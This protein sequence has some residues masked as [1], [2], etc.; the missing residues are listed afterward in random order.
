M[1][2]IGWYG[3]G[4]KVKGKYDNGDNTWIGY[5][6]VEGEFAVAYYGIS[7]VYGNKQNLNKFLNEINIKEALTMGYD[8]TYKN[9]IDLNNPNQ[10]CGNGVYL[11]QDPKI[12]ENTAGIVDIGGVRYKVLL[13]CRVNPKKIRKPKGFENCWILNSTPSEIR[14]YRILVKKI[15]KS[16]MAGASQNEIK[17]FSSHPQYFQDIIHKK[18]TSF[19]STNKSKLNNDNYVINLYTS[20]DY[21]YINNY[22][23]EGQLTDTSKY[24]ENQIKSW[25][26]CLHNS[27]TNKASNV[28]NGSIYY[29]GVARKFP[30]NLG[31]GSK[32]IFGEFTSVSQDINVALCFASNETLF[33]IRIENNNYPNCYCYDISNMSQY[34]HEKEILITS[35]CTFHI[36]KK[37]DKDEDKNSVEKIYLTCEGF[38]GK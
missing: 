8:Q 32:F 15:F 2:P 12:A 9:D 18:D 31:V 10:I 13:M 19:F 20:N 34:K 36:T 16:A 27:L 38:K 28:K 21:R 29:R 11:F 6:N 33:I 23:R 24:T 7:N 3:Y 37:E 35:N 4:L 5:Y 22:L 26:W 25:V 17:T 14:P 30:D 1:P